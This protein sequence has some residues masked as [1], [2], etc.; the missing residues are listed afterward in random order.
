MDPELAGRA[1]PR[2]A[3]ATTGRTVHPPKRKLSF[4]SRVF[5]YDI[6]LSFALGPPPRGTHSYAS[7][8]ARSL[9]ERDFSVFFSEDEAPPGNELDRTLRA[10]LLHSRILVVIANHETLQEPRWV[11]TEVEEFR[12]YRADRP[13]VVI[14]IGGALQDPVLAQSSQEW[15]GYRGRIWLDESRQTVED[16]IA[17]QDVV[18]RL[19]TAPMRATKGKHGMEHSIAHALA[20]LQ[21]GRV[22]ALSGDKAK[23]KAAYET[24]LALW[25]GADP[26]TPVLK[27]AKAE[28]ARL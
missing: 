17:S 25:K 1:A 26:T 23:A 9:R 28:Y 16:G 5:G 13:I 12:K 15:L 21:L 14:N 18:E 2:S 11:R 20:H 22:F 24:F 27:S 6:F 3:P 4:A 19:A 8:L 7:D 10:A